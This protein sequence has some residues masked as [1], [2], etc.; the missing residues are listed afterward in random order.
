[1][2][3]LLCPV[4]GNIQIYYYDAYNYNIA[5]V[6]MNDDVDIDILLDS[7]KLTESTDIMTLLFT[8]SINAY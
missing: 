1:M 5:P 3:E 2:L 6:A 8:I 7:D 4:C